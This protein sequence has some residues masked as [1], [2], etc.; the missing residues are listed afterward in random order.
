MVKGL[1]FIYTI[2]KELENSKAVKIMK[3]ANKV[4]DKY[5]DNKDKIR[6]EITYKLED[7]KICWLI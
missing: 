3:I 6:P 7:N 4:M 1:S 2:S 5:I